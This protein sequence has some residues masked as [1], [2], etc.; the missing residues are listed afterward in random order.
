MQQHRHLTCIDDRIYNYFMITVRSFIWITCTVI[1]ESVLLGLSVC[2]C[3]YVNWHIA[4]LRY[5]SH[6]QSQSQSIHQNEKIIKQQRVK[7]NHSLW[8]SLIYSLSFSIFYMIES[9]FMHA[10]ICEKKNPAIHLHTNSFMTIKK[11]I[12]LGK[13]K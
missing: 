10:K 11:W 4:L 2:M 5:Q 1:S 12:F 3:S 7:I 13:E 9:H 6:S 8:M